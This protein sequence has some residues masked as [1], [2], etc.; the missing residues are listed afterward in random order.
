MQIDSS[1]ESITYLAIIGRH[2]DMNMIAQYQRCS[3]LSAASSFGM[4]QA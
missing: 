4:W 3:R 2:G 1:G